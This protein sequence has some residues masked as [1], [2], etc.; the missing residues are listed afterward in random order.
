MLNQY[1][2]YAVHAVY[3][4]SGTVDMQIINCVIFCY[5]WFPWFSAEDPAQDLDSSEST[6]GRMQA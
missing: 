5:I 2:F 6:F 4:Q 3:G 1:T